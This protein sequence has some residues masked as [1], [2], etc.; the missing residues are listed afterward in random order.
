M[1]FAA[2]SITIEPER[3]LMLEEAV[4][5]AEEAHP[6]LSASEALYAFMGWLTTRTEPLTVS[7]HDDA[8]P[9]VPL[10][11]E[12]SIRNDLMEPRPGWDDLVVPNPAEG[13]VFA[14]RG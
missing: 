11:E 6:P 5:A 2:P 14:D 4:A 7:S 9:V 12:F 3:R 8:A 13:T 1:A 10:I